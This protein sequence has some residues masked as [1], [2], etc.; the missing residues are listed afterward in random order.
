M[1]VG[2]STVVIAKDMQALYVHQGVVALL[3]S[4]CVSDCN[5][6]YLEPFLENHST[7]LSFLMAEA[8]AILTESRALRSRCSLVLGLY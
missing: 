2:T 7:K 6:R 5:Q 3:M 8:L 1:Y 4:F